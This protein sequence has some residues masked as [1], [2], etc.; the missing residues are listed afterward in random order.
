MGLAILEQ[1]S[2][3]DLG[4]SAAARMVDYSRFDKIDDL[5]SDDEQQEQ[6][7]ATPQLAP[8]PKPVQTTQKGKD[9]R[10]KF[11]YEGTM[12]SKAL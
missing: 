1:L 10:I 9:G 12:C 7:I 5:D 4:H 6:K 8:A 11:E 3:R 2:C